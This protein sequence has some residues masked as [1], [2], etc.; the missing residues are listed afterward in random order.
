MS[1]HLHILTS[2]LNPTGTN[3]GNALSVWVDCRRWS[4][5]QLPNKTRDWRWEW[6]CN[7]VLSGMVVLMVNSDWYP[8]I[9][10]H[11]LSLCIHVSA[12]FLS[13]SHTLPSL[14]LNLSITFHLNPS[15][16][17]SLLLPCPDLVCTHNRYWTQQGWCEQWH[18][19]RMRAASGSS[20]WPEDQTRLPA[21]VRI[22]IPFWSTCILNSS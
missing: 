16:F 11:L 10:H 7:W 8:V 4:H 1:H 12:N 5:S 22:P 14:C 15:F 18:T 19:V 6:C 20:L 9:V 2:L 21:L 17:L 3:E 13:L